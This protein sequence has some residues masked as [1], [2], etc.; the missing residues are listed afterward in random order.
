M[1]MMSVIM[2]MPP[3]VVNVPRL[4]GVGHLVEDAGDAEGIQVAT[5][6]FVWA[7]ETAGGDVLKVVQPTGMGPVVTAS[8]VG[9]L[10]RRGG[11]SLTSASNL[12]G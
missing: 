6:R 3:E 7:E 10:F 9:L 11:L 5:D 1:R 8:S 2:G 4:G 12:I